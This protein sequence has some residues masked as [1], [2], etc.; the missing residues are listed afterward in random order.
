M[1]VSALGIGLGL[2]ISGCGI[3][4]DPEMRTIDRKAIPFRLSDTST[5]T[6]PPTS[7]TTTTTPNP[8]STTSTVPP[9]TQPPVYEPVTLYFAW[10]DRV[11]EVKRLLTQQPRIDEVINMLAFGPLPGEAPPDARSAVEVGD[12]EGVTVS[13][14]VAI[15]QLANKFRD[16]PAAEQR[17]SVAQLV[18]T[19]TSRPGVGQVRFTVQGVALKVP[20]ADGTFGE[21][22]ASRDDYLGMIV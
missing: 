20:R 21:S 15:V 7:T 17:K 4:T 18:L 6:V 10:S 5:S 16:L 8:T 2:V 12:V 22:E 9:S 1:I 14:G 19:L 13:G 11:V 3:P